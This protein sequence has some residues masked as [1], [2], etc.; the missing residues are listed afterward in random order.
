M[1]RFVR[2]CDA[3]N[4]PIITLVDVPGF[5][6]GVDQEHG[7]IIRHGAKL[8]LRV[9]KPRCPRSRVI[10]RKAYGG[11]YIVMSSKSIGADLCFAWPTAEIA[12]MGPKG[13]VS[14]LYTRQ[15]KA[16]RADPREDGAGASRARDAGSLQLAVRRRLH[17]LHRRRDLPAGDAGKCGGRARVLRDKQSPA[18][19]KKHGNI[20]L[21]AMSPQMS[22]SLQIAGAAA[23][24][25][26]LAIGALVGLMYLLTNPSIFGEP[27]RERRRARRTARRLK[28]RRGTA[29]A[30]SVDVADAREERLEEHDRRRRAAA[31]AV[32]VACAEHDTSAIGYIDAPPRWRLLHRDLR[33]QQRVEPRR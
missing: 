11:A 12:V 8:A 30:P 16:R 4:I 18:L 33:L 1:A 21:V 9:C 10:L 7:G 14:I 31:L 17:R 6:P 19:P 13:A 23:A 24:L 20:P 2:M 26:T 15:L 3:F 28:K 27:A 22:V 32:A 5:L 25:L 29:A